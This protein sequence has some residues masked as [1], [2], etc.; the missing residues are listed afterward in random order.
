MTNLWSYEHSPCLS[1]GDCTVPATIMIVRE[2]TGPY[3]I[4]HHW[5]KQRF[6]R[7]FRIDRYGRR[8]RTPPYRSYEGSFVEAR[9]GSRNRTKSQITIEQESNGI[10]PTS[11]AQKGQSAALVQI[12]VECR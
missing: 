2:C 11:T 7:V 1:H 5:K 12:T 10:D 8:N 9:S 4:S 6:Q 3:A